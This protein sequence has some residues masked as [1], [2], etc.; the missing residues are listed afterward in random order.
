M[1]RRSGPVVWVGIIASTCLLLLFF[2][3]ISGWWCPSCWP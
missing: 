3:K 1:N 2:K